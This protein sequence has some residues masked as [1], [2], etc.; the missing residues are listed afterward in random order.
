[1]NYAL[2]SL[3]DL[4]DWS[5]SRPASGFHGHLSPPVVRVRPSVS[6]LTSESEPVW[7]NATDSRLFELRA[8]G[9]NWDG[10]GSAA[11]RPDTLSFAL[12]LLSRVM[13]PATPSPSIVPLGHGGVQL[14]WTSP[15][16]ELEVELVEPNKVIIYHYNKENDEEREWETETEL[17]QLSRLL[18]SDFAG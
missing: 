8:L 9:H 17:S 16:A 2:Q 11:I 13:G 1:M 12:T 6:P 7:R 5:G 18:R 4:D 3:A 10:R 15:R 14:I